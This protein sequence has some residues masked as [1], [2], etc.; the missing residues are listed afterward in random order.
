MWSIRGFHRRIPLGPTI[1]ALT[2]ITLLVLTNVCGSG[3]GVQARHKG[4]GPSPADIPPQLPAQD[5]SIEATPAP[6]GGTAPTSGGSPTTNG[7]PVPAPTV[8]VTETVTAPPGN[9]PS[10]GGRPGNAPATSAPGGQSGGSGGST[11]TAVPGGASP[12]PPPPL[13][14]RFRVSGLRL[15]ADRANGSWVRCNGIDQVEFLGT[16]VVDGPGPGDVVFQWVSDL[17]FTLPQDV[18]HFTGTGPRQQTI[19]I[20]W[21]IPPQLFGEVSG[22]MQLLILQPVANAQTERYTFN[23][24]CRN[25]LSNDN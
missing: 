6:S 7:Q 13:G 20:T 9:T 22:I 19:P 14:Q 18:L 4:T 23:F 24:N 1:I 10:S 8:T 12:T 21:R 3:P 5:Q 16:V 11:A 15:S 17:P 2:L 25:G